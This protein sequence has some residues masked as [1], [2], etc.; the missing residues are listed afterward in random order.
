MRANIYVSA[1]FKD[2]E[3]HREAVR[4]AIRG[5]EHVDVSMEHYVAEPK[6]PLVRCLD[7]VQRCDLYIGLFGRR[8]GFV[9]SGSDRS[10]TE[11]EYR[12]A[13]KHGKDVLC[14][15]LRDDVQWPAEFIDQGEAAKKLKAL[16][17][18]ISSNYLTSFFSTPDEL[19]TKVTA[20]I[21]RALQLGTTPMDVGREHR[22]MKEW[23]EGAS[24]AHRVKARHA[25]FNMGSPRYAAAIKDFLLDA[26]NKDV[27]DIATFMGELLTLS[28]NSRQ[29]M[30]IFVDLLQSDMSAT[31][32]FAVVQIGELGKRGKEIHVDIIRA[33]TKLDKDTNAD[34]REQ[35]AHT[36][37]KIHHFE[38]ALPA[39]RVCLEKLTQDGHEVVR[40]RAEE[41]QG[42]I[43]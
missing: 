43:A 17:D 16:R 24:R 7:D 41:S 3:V 28:V 15:L 32:F 11:L 19:A 20:A 12:A 22:L 5:L 6:R 35:L 18:E 42:L 10:I 8:Y 31:R 30:P 4:E 27:E 21:V 25:L 36:L 14:F 39:V 37:G 23:R 38:E 33:L 13:L 1:T 9:P 2:L 29:V 34:V 40:K 26:K